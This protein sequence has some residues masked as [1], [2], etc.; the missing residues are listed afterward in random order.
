MD[1]PESY[2]RRWWHSYE[3]TVLL[4]IAISAALGLGGLGWQA[5]IVGHRRAMRN[6][7]EASGGSVNYFGYSGP[8]EAFVI[9]K[10][11]AAGGN[12]GIS[13]IRRLLGD[14]VISEVYFRR[15]ITAAD[16][17]AMEAFP[18]AELWGVPDS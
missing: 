10:I 9:A 12:R 2:R 15:Q 6:Q 5:S 3:W 18:E 16:R 7:I 13:P 1:A 8:P 11:R 4:A 17:K 14:Q